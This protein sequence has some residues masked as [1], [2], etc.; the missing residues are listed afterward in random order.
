MT[1]MVIN[2]VSAWQHVVKRG[3]AHW[4]LLSSVV[5]GVLLA[6]AIMAGTVIYFD[7]LKQL[8]LK[9]TLEEY[10]TTELDVLVQGQRGPVS[11][12][13]HEKLT[14]L[15]EGEVDLRLDWMLRDVIRGAKS[16]TFFLTPPGSE[17]LAGED[18]ARTYFAFL[19]RLHEHV[20]L[21][22]GG[23]FPSGQS[24]SQPGEPVLL[25]AII[26]QEAA[27]LFD[28]GVG[29]RLV[30][31]PPWKDTTPYITVVVTGVFERKDPGDE[32][33][34]MERS[35]L[36]SATGPSF[37]TVPFHVAEGAFFEVLGP[38]FRRME[39][40][41]AWLLAV[42]I[43]RVNAWNAETTLHD[44]QVMRRVLGPKVSG[45]RQS[46]SLDDALRDYDR[47][48]FFS[49]LPMFVVLI[50]IAVVVLYYVVTLSSLTVEDRRGEVALLRSRGASTA[51]ILA[52]FVLE[53]ATIAVLAA[54]VGP[55]LAA[56]TISILGLTPAFA[57]LSGGARLTVT[58]SG[59]AYMMSALGG[60]LGFVALIVPAAQASRIGVTQQRQQAARP[61]TQPAFQRYYLDVMLLLLSIFL[62]RQLTEQGS[63]VATRLFG[64]LAV[65]Q[66][67]LA[68][69]GVMLVAS[70]M[71]LL[72]LFP[73]VMGLAS[74]ALSPWLPS[75]LVLGVWQM[76]R[77]PTHYARLSLLLILTAGLGIFA[78]SFGA[79]L[80]RSFRERVY[81]FTG[82]DLRV[83]GVTPIDRR[84]G[85]SRGPGRRRPVWVPMSVA[86][87]ADTYEQ[88]PGVERASP[89]L[90]TVG[91]DLSRFYGESYKM[92]AVDGKSFGDVAWFRD[93]FADEPMAGLLESLTAGSPPQGI[94]LPEDATAIG[95]RIKADRPHPGI[96][97]SARVRTAHDRYVTYSLGR[98]DS[99]G[100][101]DLERSLSLGTLQPDESSLPLTLV[102]LRVHE[103]N[104][105][106][107]LQAGWILI[108]EIWVKTGSGQTKTLEAFDDADGWGVLKV[109]PE[110]IADVLTPSDVGFN[111]DS[112]SVLLS[113]SDGS[114]LTARGIFHGEERSSLPVLASKAFLKAT[115]HMV[116]EEFDVSAGGYR[117]PVRLVEAVDLFPTMTTA[118]ESFL[119]VDLVSL[120][121]YANLGAVG[122]ELLPNA[123]WV[124]TIADGIPAE[125]VVQGLGNV[126]GY[127]SSVIIDKEERL[128]QAKVDPLV[129][130]GW[131]ALLFIAFS[132]VLILSCLGFLVHAYVSFKN[133]QLQFALLR[134]VGFSIRQLET[135]V[136]LEQAM[137]IGL[138]MGLG[139]WMGG[140]LGA[141]IMPF[142]GHDDWG[143]EVLPPFALEVNWGTLLITYA[144]MFFVFAIITLGV[145]WLIHRISLQ[146]ILRLG[147]M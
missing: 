50:L 119:V 92:L 63:V 53:G 136:W 111:G 58:I 46:T 79:T 121:R 9:K 17:D 88:V 10:T 117:I 146:R 97:V 69:P 19:P 54:L 80:E 68:V 75:G 73:L 22:P 109:A 74:R 72:R 21:L 6:S 28:V 105:S 29:D 3:L 13:E 100:W 127:T 104:P 49:K 36:Q 51:Q 48:L 145:I 82:S 31:V 94:T 35:V 86:G 143:R 124:S 39:S 66:L 137:V 93:D 126:T 70:A 84:V 55:L 26:P 56:G 38:S 116:G 132:A 142:L 47:R 130:A 14:A 140:R 20:E 113:W 23:T 61:S 15:V 114:A 67:L 45:Y 44:I 107:R 2:L 99:R 129:E 40:T 71:V 52:V 32:F 91:Q 135:M 33:W 122:R 57:D 96:T 87:V 65:D 90:R 34:Y 133:R 18:N 41:Y 123:V 101:A 139:T 37:R 4:R 138:G 115:D 98:L 141:T 147:E 12:E 5:L 27:V 131:R 89:V 103:S 108:D 128:A 59:G 42:D 16:P 76:S 144:A 120:T 95:V 118:D 85:S 60:V 110:S 102:S 24:R 1:G 8:A 81:F 83:E 106:R 125:E 64:E 11:R 43:G 112:G 62:F 77:N 30:A 25:E 7:A 78:A 134:T